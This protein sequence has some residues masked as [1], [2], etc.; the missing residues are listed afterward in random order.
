VLDHVSTRAAHVV[1]CLDRLRPADLHLVLRFRHT[2]VSYNDMP[3]WHVSTPPLHN[4]VN[5]SQMCIGASRLH[6]AIKPNDAII[7]FLQLVTAMTQLKLSYTD[8]PKKHGPR[9]RWHCK[10]HE[11][12]CPIA[13]V[14][15]HQ[16]DATMHHRLRRTKT[17][18]QN[19]T[20]PRQLRSHVWL[21]PKG[22]LRIALTRPTP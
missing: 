13:N 6:Q 10:V 16:C 1:S 2:G 21:T 5:P 3:G 12:A 17:N 18:G 11:T 8:V 20:V 4:L 7:T 19:S 9:S 15:S 14:P 22:P